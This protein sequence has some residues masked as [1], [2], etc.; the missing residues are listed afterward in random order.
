MS[1]M[2]KLID[3]VVRCTKCNAKLGEC[4]CWEKKSVKKKK[5]SHKPDA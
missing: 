5:R 2:D 4:N 3:S 1:L